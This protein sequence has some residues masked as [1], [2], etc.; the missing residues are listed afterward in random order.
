MDLLLLLT[1]AVALILLV[2]LLTRIGSLEQKN[3][4]LKSDLREILAE[5][6]M[7]RRHEQSSAIAPKAVSPLAE[8]AFRVYSCSRAG[9]R[10]TAFG[11]DATATAPQ[12]HSSDAE[13]ISHPGTYGACLRSI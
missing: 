12:N 1:A 13:G 2:S 11:G 6:R 5:I 4:V 7:L 3:D 8:A 10:I 9:P